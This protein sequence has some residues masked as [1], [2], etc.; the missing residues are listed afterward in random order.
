MRNRLLGSWILVVVLAVLSLR[1]APA[2]AEV[3]AGVSYTV[4]KG[5]AAADR[6]ALRILAPS[7]QKA[8]EL[9]VA[10]V[11]GVQP[12]SGSPDDQ[13]ASLAATYNADAKVAAAS[14]VSITDRGAAGKLY[15]KS[16]DVE[17]ADLGAHTRMLAV[18]VRGDLRGVILFVF[19]SNAVLRAHGAAVQELMKSLAIVAKPGSVTAPVVPAAP[20]TLPASGTDGALPTGETAGYLGSPGWRPSGRGV[21]IPPVPRFV[22]GRPVGL[23]WRYQA[24]ATKMFPLLMIYLPDGTVASNP[25][26]GG[27]ALFDVD[28]QRK[29]PN[30]TGVGTFTVQ[31]GKITQVIDSFT[32]TDTFKS[33]TDKDGLWFEIGAGRHYPLEPVSAKEMVG[34]WRSPSGKLTFRADGTYES[35]TVIVNSEVTAAQGSGGTWQAD[36]YLVW[37]RS[38]KGADWMS[39]VGRTGKLLVVG[40]TVYKRE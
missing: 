17:N 26:F 36:G 13:I 15:M 29:Q 32:Q 2:F 7:E 33:G 4:P 9:M 6:G 27:G 34:T 30:R 10:M 16:F 39:S 40:Q 20:A 19:T 22:D 28:G 8:G 35:G 31:A 21:K 38:A 3:T 37:F 25:R 14:A 18:L 11:V 1:P 12:A 23:W 24:D 5:W